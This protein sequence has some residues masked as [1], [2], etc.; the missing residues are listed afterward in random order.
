MLVD[1]CLW[2]GALVEE[3]GHILGK[4]WVRKAIPIVASM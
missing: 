1:G 3:W 2:L 4:K